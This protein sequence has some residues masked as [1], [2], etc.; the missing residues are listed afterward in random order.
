METLDHRRRRVGAHNAG[1]EQAD[2]EAQREL[3]Q[4]ALSQNQVTSQDDLRTPRAQGGVLTGAQGAAMLGTTSPG[5]MELGI[6]ASPFHSELIQ[7]EVALRRSRPATLDRDAQALERG[8]HDPDEVPF[9]PK[10]GAV[11]IARIEGSQGEEV[12]RAPSGKPQTF[13][14]SLHPSGEGATGPSLAV[15]AS[16]GSASARS[17]PGEVPRPRL[18]D[19]VAAGPGVRAKESEED[20]PELEASNL[21]LAL[22]DAVQSARPA[23]TDSRE[24]VPVETSGPSR[25]EQLLAQLLEENRN[26]RLRLDQVETQSSWHSGG[27][28]LTGVEQSPVSFGIGGHGEFMGV[29]S[30]RRALTEG[31]PGNDGQGPRLQGYPELLDGDSTGRGAEVALR[32]LRALHGPVAVPPLPTRVRSQVPPPPPVHPPSHQLVEYGYQSLAREVDFE[33]ERAELFGLGLEAST[34]LASGVEEVR[35][36]GVDVQ[37]FDYRLGRQACAGLGSGAA[38]VAA[39]G[40]DAWARPGHMGTN[41]F[42]ADGYPVF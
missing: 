31:I 24:L 25:V 33:C 13:Q 5:M 21:A 3:S 15:G 4:A 17:S 16:A 18:L 27:T 19:G 20:G 7:G 32:R 22:I 12:P 23:P 39:T 28:R 8:P 14:P 11:R 2:V 30:A 35:S 37:G 42:T 1:E 40:V 38:G 36:G 41:R 34:G 6:V 29:N 10:Y 9:D 26:L